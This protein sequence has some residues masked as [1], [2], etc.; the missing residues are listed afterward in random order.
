VD[1]FN[2]AQVR[3]RWWDIVKA[4]IVLSGSINGRD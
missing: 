4:V 3:D 1:W 2:V